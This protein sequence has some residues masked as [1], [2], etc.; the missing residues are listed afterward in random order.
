MCL[1]HFWF[2]W[3]IYPAVGLLGH[4]EV[5]FP[6]FKGIFTLFSIIVVLVCRRFTAIQAYL[7]KQE[8]HQINNLTLHL[9]QLE[10]E[11]KDSKV[12]RRK[13]IIKI[14]NFYADSN[15]STCVHAQSCLTVISWTV[16]HQAPLFMVFPRQEYWSGLPFPTPRDL[17]NPG[18]K[19]VSSAL[20][21][22]F[23]TTAP[24]GKS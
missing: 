14:T 11:E 8:K 3:C 5:L 15:W 19:L 4:I 18:I 21:G 16:A 24:P 23:F 2:P 10:K 6:V 20:A 7:K 12:S 13:E 1:F 9:K 22:R 17:P